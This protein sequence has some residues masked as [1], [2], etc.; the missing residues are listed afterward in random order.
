MLRGC[1]TTSPVEIVVTA[2]VLRCAPGTYHQLRFSR[3]P[4]LETLSNPTRCHPH[5]AGKP[6]QLPVIS[7]PP[8][9]DKSCHL[10][11]L[12]P[13]ALRH[14]TC[15]THISLVLRFVRNTEANGTPSSR[16]CETTPERTARKRPIFVSYKRARTLCFV[17]CVCGV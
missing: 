16:T 13:P 15:P 12:P 2:A 7:N 10:N 9:R 5:R 4:C 8:N 14:G 3:A 6:R 11:R 17:L 1:D